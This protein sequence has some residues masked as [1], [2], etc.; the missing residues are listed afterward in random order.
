MIQLWCKP[1]VLLAGCR[2]LHL[3]HKVCVTSPQG[4]GPPLCSD[5]LV[6]LV[7]SN[8][9]HGGS[10]L[11]IL[12]VRYFGDRLERLLPRLRSK[13]ATILPTASTGL[14]RACQ[15]SALLCRKRLRNKTACRA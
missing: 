1:V 13:H 9:R 15:S 3:W 7:V 14:T 6:L 12:Q 11:L 4:H 5:L 2:A 8:A 10:E